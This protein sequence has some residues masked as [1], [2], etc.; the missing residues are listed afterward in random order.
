MTHNHQAVDGSTTG[1]ALVLVLA[2]GYE[3]MALCQQRGRPWPDA[4]TAAFL[5]GCLVLAA[6]LSP[7][8]SPW[9]FGDFRTHMLQ[10]L[11]VGMVAPLGLV[12]GAP[13]TLV[14]RSVPRPLGRRLG[15]LLHH[16]ALRPVAHPVTALVLSVGGFA[17]LYVTPL[18][19]VTADR[20]ALH[21]L[22]TVHFLLA[23]CLFAW[24]IAGPDPAPRRPSV[25]ARLVVLGIAVA[26]HAILSQ[27]LYAGV[28]APTEIPTPQRQGGATLMYY[29]GDIT[30]LLVAAA[31][32][33]TWRPTR[34]RARPSPGPRSGAS[35]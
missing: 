4:R 10:H 30:E 28:M 2:V 27:L 18:Y 13:I 1:V 5:G 17:A 25:P 16:R 3:V 34:V 6:G 33:A 11:L 20:P 35:A 7:E 23:G 22:M 9:P 19:T 29:G 24:V 32:V 31:L 12:L 8:L 21:T 15:R 26:A 14:L